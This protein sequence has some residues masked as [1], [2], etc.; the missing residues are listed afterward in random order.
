MFYQ[1]LLVAASFL[2]S[3]MAQSDFATAMTTQQNHY[4]A[5][6]GVANLTWST[7][8]ATAAQTHVSSCNFALYTGAGGYGQILAA[9]GFDPVQTVVDFWYSQEANY[10]YNNPVFSQDTGAFTQL[11]WKATTEVGCGQQDCDGLKGTPGVFVA[12][13]YR[14][15]GNVQGRFRA[16]VLPPVSSAA[17]TK[18][19]AK[20]DVAAGERR[21]LA[22]GF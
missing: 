12:C 20:V 13:F 21:V 2:A 14:P 5:L 6:H 7:T 18:A 17:A 4:R 19:Q 11:V 15:A 10:D 9:G 16:N 8:I 3:C 1:T 22:A